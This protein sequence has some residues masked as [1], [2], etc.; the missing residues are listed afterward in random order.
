MDP[1][2]DAKPMGRVARRR[3]RN[4]AALIESARAVMAQRGIDAATMAEIAERADV[5]AG[6]IYSFFRSKDDLAVA[7]LEELMLDLALRIQAV[8]DGFKDPAEVYAFGLR[9]VIHAATH[10]PHWRQLLYRSEVLA[11]AMFDRMG[12][13]AM[14][15]LRNANEAGRFRVADP[16]VTFRM[17]SYAIVGVALAIAE[18]DLPESAVEEAIISLLSMTGIGRAEAED[19]ARRDR[20]PLPI[21]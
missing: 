4:R 9:T 10:D 12:P 16:A 17:A 14:R 11:S 20:P 2:D 21:G 8:T 6:T 18:G 19:L 1:A 7:V 5:A 15:D 13:F 3:T